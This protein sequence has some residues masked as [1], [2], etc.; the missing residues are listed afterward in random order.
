MYIDK[1]IKADE[2]PLFICPGCTHGTVT[3]AFVKVADELKLDKDKTILVC[4]IGCAGRIPTFL[5]FSVLRVTHG[6][7]LAFA[8]GIKLAR[9][10]VKVIVFMG[11]GDA[12][13]IGGNH[14]IHA[15]RRNID[16]TAIISMN[17]IYGMTG[18][19]YAPTTS[20]GSMTTTSPFGMIEN[21]FDICTLVE[22]AGATYV[23][24]SDAYHVKHLQKVLKNA[25]SHEGFSV[26]EAITSCPTQYGRRNKESD[27]S[28]MLETIKNTTIFK[29]VAA[30]LPPE[31]LKE[32]V[33]IGEFVNKVKPTLD[34]QYLELEARFGEMVFESNVDDVK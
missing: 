19:Q 18:G 13:A 11:D 20:R 3:N 22:G 10:D 4:A 34:Q 31:E 26:V 17:E 25:I 8:T 32:K 1:Y 24:R 16:I 33:V 5:D 9:P 6:R 28:K 29:E 12:A 2:F 15:A 7:A 14:L 23:A 30:K 27:P 21:T